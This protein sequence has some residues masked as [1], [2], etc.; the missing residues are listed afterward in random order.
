[1]SLTT[2]ITSAVGEVIGLDP[3]TITYSGTNYTG[4][5][6]YGL[7]NQLAMQD[8]GYNR[9]DDLHAIIKV[10]ELNGATPAVNDTFTINSVTYRIVSRN[11]S[12]AFNLYKLHRRV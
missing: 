5:V 9:D 12:G 8:A 2:E 11:V 7:A 6:F 1:M 10:S 4:R 3:A